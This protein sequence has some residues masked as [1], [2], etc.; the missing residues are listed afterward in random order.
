MHDYRRL[1]VWVKSHELA[2]D[3]HR[4]A[5]SA[6]G[7]ALVHLELR[8]AALEV[9]VRIVRGCEA[10]EAG[11]FAAAM[12]DAAAA[13]DELGYRL[14]FARDAAAIDDVPFARLEARVSQV[15]AMLGGLNRTARIRLG[16]AVRPAATR[17]AVP[18]PA[19]TAPAATRAG[20]GRPAAVRE[21]RDGPGGGSSPPRSRP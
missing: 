14:R 16:A 10:E 19:A 17:S 18:R 6:A 7:G 9:P 21:R 11:E 15:R 1:D 20:A 2:V 8:A 12:R 3:V 4:L 5:T 13:A